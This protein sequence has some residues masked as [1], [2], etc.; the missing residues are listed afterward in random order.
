[1]NDFSRATWVHLMSRKSNAFPLLK[2]FILFIE[3]Q[4]STTVKSLGTDNALEFSSSF[5]QTF[6]Q[7]KGIVH[8]QSCVYTTQQNGHILEIALAFMFQSNLP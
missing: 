4:F 7:S 3:N 2:S 6:Y 1:M 5:A 8:Q